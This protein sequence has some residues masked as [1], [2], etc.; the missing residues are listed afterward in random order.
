M[1][2]TGACLPYD[3]EFVHRDGHRVPVLTGAAVL[4]CNP[5][6]WAT[7]IV[8]LTARQ[9]AEQE[10]AE[11]LASARTARVKADSAREQLDFLL[12]AGAWSLRPGPG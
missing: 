8:D 5:L 9:R 2:R 12:R 7:F 11:L 10:R 4:D 6:R 1:R 3:K